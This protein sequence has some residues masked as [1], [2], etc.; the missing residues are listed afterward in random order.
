MNGPDA[1]STGTSRDRLDGLMPEIYGELRSLAQRAMSS[2]RAGHT[3]QTTALVHEAYLRLARAKDLDVGCR[4]QF[5]A[6]AARV[7]RQI[8]VDH[9]RARHSAKRGGSA[10]RVALSEEIPAEGTDGFDVLALDEALDRLAA[11][12]AKQVQIVE[13]RFIAGLSVEETAEVIATSP[14]TVKRESAIARAWL[15][16]ELRDGRSRPH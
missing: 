13:L 3:L 15:F 4:P 7:M 6:L 12:D 10:F 2:E 9:A 11:L 16:R 14:T 8:L 1:G 5:L